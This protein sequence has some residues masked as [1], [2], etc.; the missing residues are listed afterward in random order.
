MVGVKI[1]NY[2][3]GVA[4]QSFEADSLSG[5]R[6]SSIR[7]SG[8][9]TEQVETCLELDLEAWRDLVLYFFGCCGC[10]WTSTA[11]GRAPAPPPCWCIGSNNGEV[12]WSSIINCVEFLG[13]FSKGP[14]VGRKI[15]FLEVGGGLRWLCPPWAWLRWLLLLWPSLLP[16]KGGG[17]KFNFSQKKSWFFIR[18]KNCIFVT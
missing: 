5:D 8:G 12:S 9:P 1:Y 7:S 6:T 10:W 2:I 15:K 14:L 17:K 13:A 16:E 11:A 4:W 18:Q 3:P